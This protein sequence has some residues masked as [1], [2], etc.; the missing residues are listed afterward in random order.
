[1]L[2]DSLLLCCRGLAAGGVALGSKLAMVAKAGGGAG[3]V[4]KGI[5]A[6][7][8]AGN[9]TNIARSFPYHSH[10]KTQGD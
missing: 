2:T 9:I 1:M 6:L 10:A 4:L 3:G 8:A 7:T 5:G